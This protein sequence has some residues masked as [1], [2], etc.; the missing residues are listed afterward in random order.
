M[1]TFRKKKQNSHDYAGF[2][3]PEGRKCESSAALASS[4]I[5]PAGSRI[6]RRYK[7]SQQERALRA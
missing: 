7:P 5:M 2:W 4:A 6:T 1:A 3:S